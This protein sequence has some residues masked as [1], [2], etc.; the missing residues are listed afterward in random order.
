MKMKKLIVIGLIL[1]MVMAIGAETIFAADDNIRVV[2]PKFMP[3]QGILVSATPDVVAYRGPDLSTAGTDLHASLLPWT[4][5]LRVKVDNAS[6]VPMKKRVGILGYKVKIYSYIDFP[7]TLE[8]EV[9]DLQYDAEGCVIAYTRISRE[10][11]GGDVD[12][13]TTTQWNALPGGEGDP[14]I[15]FKAYS[16]PANSSIELGVLSED[17]MPGRYEY[18]D[19]KVG[20]V[21]SGTI[22]IRPQIPGVVKVGTG[23]IIG[24]TNGSYVIQPYD[25]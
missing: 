18:S 9:T 20:I 24:I 1:T 10:K 21:E 15:G 11:K 23:N 14:R 13:T 6:T 17:K 3:R 8:I 2:Q 16:V 4:L 12:F 22:I 25:L 5:G 7:L 19:I